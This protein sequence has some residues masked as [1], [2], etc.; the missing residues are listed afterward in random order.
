MSYLVQVR[1]AAVKSLR[2][3]HPQDRNRVKGAIKLLAE[4]PFPPGAKNLKGRPGYR[5]RV[6]EYRIIYTVENNIL[7][8]TVVQVGHRREIYR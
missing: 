8:I 3:I 6:G 2:K 7:L 4:N 1:P 5:I